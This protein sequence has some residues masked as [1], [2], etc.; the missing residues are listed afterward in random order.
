MKNA[1]IW[2]VGFAAILMAIVTTMCMTVPVVMIPFMAASLQTSMTSISLYVSI[3]AVGTLISS[4]L[5]GALVKKIPIKVLI[6]A[7]GI[8]A[9]LLYV[10]IGSTTSLPIIY[11]TAFLQGIGNCIAGIAMAQI[12]LSQ[13]FIKAF[14]TMMSFCVVGLMVCAAVLLPILTSI[15]IA[16]GYQIVS[17]W[18]G[19][20][21]AVIVALLGLFVIVD[22]PARVGLK[23]L[24]YVEVA[25]GEGADQAAAHGGA[26]VVSFTLKQA[27]KTSP[28]WIILIF[29]LI[30]VTGSQ[31]IG[32]QALNYY[33]SIG[34]DAT[35][36]SFMLSL[37]AMT[38]M[39]FS[40]LAGIIC[41][42][43]SPTHT[44]VLTIGFGA[45]AF[46][47][48]FIWSGFIGAVIAAVCFAGLS[49]SMVYAPM[50]MMR[51]FGTKDAGSLIGFGNGAGN[52][53]SF[54]GPVLAASFFD[55]M[56]TYTYVYMGIGVALVFIL[57]LSLKAG[58][59]KTA[60]NLRA[61]ES[62]QS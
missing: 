44:A 11:A 61:K 50:M 47:G 18:F 26:S 8:M 56:G 3:S 58:S 21:V 34:L 52:L 15:I 23:P 28:F 35:T 4:F 43:K 7:G 53:G 27:V 62:S 36:A 9:G 39:V 22:S 6:I 31:G 46:L 32:S 42:K 10:T 30:S 59:K 17:F 20:C 14:G 57:L 16:N 60:E 13:W 5:L 40:L 25:A 37:N 19:V 51:L 33:Q 41:D 1:R 12:V 24:G 54:L 49:G 38:G 29:M 2:V 55:M 45:I 48:A